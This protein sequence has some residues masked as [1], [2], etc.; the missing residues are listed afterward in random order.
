MHRPADVRLSQGQSPGLGRRLKEYCDDRHVDIV[1][2]SFIDLSPENDASGFGY[3]GFSIQAAFCGPG[4]F[5]NA[6]HSSHLLSHCETLKEDIP[7][8]QAKGIKVLLSIGGPYSGSRSYKVSTIASGKK[9]AQSLYEIF[10]PYSEDT[11]APRPFDSPG[12]H[13]AVDGFDFF[14]RTDYGS[15]AITSSRFSACR[16]G[17]VC[18][19]LC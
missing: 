6:T 3:P 12:K 7:H 1:T 17:I 14:L 5:G 9:F 18:P 19:K 11:K 4:F 8:C 10:G 15:K 13:V 2:L 16:R